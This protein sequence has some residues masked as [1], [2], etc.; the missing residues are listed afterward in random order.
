MPQWLWGNGTVASSYCSL[1]FI[2]FSLIRHLGQ[3]DIYLPTARGFDEYLGIPFSQ[4]MGLS[5]WS[6]HNY[7]PAPPYFPT[8]LPLLNGTT[9]IEQPAGLHTI[10]KRYSAAAV[11]FITDK[12]AAGIPFYL[13]VPYNHVHG[14]N[15]CGPE[16]CGKSRR[17]PIGDAVEEMD[18]SVG[19]IMGALLATG[20]DNNTLVFFTR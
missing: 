15:S 6:T 8:P 16:F 2:H 11:D 14:P 1:Q 20:V 9:T 7:N 18:W 17:G 12:S 4:D 10:V 5:F 13:Y 3:R 19:Q